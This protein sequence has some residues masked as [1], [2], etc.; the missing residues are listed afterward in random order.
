MEFSRD[1]RKIGKIQR[2]APYPSENESDSLIKAGLKLNH[3]RL[4]SAISDLGQV[5][6]AADALNISQPAAS[7]LLTEMESILEA[8]LCERVSKGVEL[9]RFGKAMAMRARSI[10]LEIREADREISEL[11][12]GYG[13]SVSI[14]SVTGPAL[15]LAVPAIRRVRG[16][17]PAIQIN[18]QIDSSNVLARD[19]IS[20][21]Y[22]FYIGRIPDEFNPRQ[23]QALALG[24]EKACLIARKDHPLAGKKAIP[25]GELATRDWVFQPAGSLLRRAIEH[26]FIESG[27]SLPDNIVS[28]S[29]VLLTTALLMESDS[30]AAI[31]AD[32]AQ[33]LTS[34]TSVMGDIVVLD[35]DFEII[36]EPV[37][38]I[39]SKGRALRPSAKLLFDAI[40][41][42]VG[43]DVG[44]RGVMRV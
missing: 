28:T 14:G 39:T 17:Y 21:R 26:L 23:F 40:L 24:A 34:R 29:S 18:C 36:L 31:A 35:T 37:S 4:I 22:D 27:A 16:S 1:V 33:Y 7:R 9:T 15:S 6:A 20:A 12:T 8:P 44:M 3:L 11:K 13:G 41:D 19:L 25:V 42:E 2:P 38:L 10:L 30:I 43:R 32:V 5:S